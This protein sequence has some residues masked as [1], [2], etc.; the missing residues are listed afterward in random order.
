MPAP[1]LAELEAMGY[2]LEVRGAYDLFFGGAQGILFDR[3][4]GEMVGGADPR[5]SGGVVGY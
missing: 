1:V 2:T 4:T 3:E 5:R